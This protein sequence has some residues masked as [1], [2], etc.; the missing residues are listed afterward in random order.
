MTFYKK[1]A[2]E[3]DEEYFLNMAKGVI[4]LLEPYASEA[5]ITKL[6]LDEPTS[7]SMADSKTASFQYIEDGNLLRL[8]INCANYRSGAF[9][10]TQAG[11]IRFL[12]EAIAD[13][14]IDLTDSLAVTKTNDY[15]VTASRYHIDEGCC[16]TLYED[17]TGYVTEAMLHYSDDLAGLDGRRAFEPLLKQLITALEPDRHEY[18]WN[19][20]DLDN[21][22]ITDLSTVEGVRSHSQYMVYNDERSFRIWSLDDDQ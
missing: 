7:I 6:K 9:T 11:L 16:L 3:N 21:F 17:E 5:I 12:N 8:L 20:L 22:K 19:Y 15:G 18:I 10:F 1:A 13:S 14:G 4:R 2:A